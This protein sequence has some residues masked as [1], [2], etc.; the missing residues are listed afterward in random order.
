MTRRAGFSTHLRLASNRRISSSS[1]QSLCIVSRL[2]T[3]TPSTRQLAR[4]STTSSLIKAILPIGMVRTRKVPIKT[5]ETCHDI[6]N[7][8]RSSTV[9]LTSTEVHKQSRDQ[10]T[11]ITPV[12]LANFKNP[13]T[14]K[15]FK[16][17]NPR[18]TQGRSTPGLTSMARQA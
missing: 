11:I 2:A 17:S 3:A 14:V 13:T 12:L 6:N 5:T 18:A 16:A 8:I 4:R 7:K 1:R 9:S 10:A 15:I